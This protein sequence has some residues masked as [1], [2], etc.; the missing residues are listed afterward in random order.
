MPDTT[1]LS[2]DWRQEIEVAVRDGLACLRCGIP[3]VDDADR[4]FVRIDPEAGDHVDNVMLACPACMNSHLTHPQPFDARGLSC[5]GEQ[6]VE[7]GP[8]GPPTP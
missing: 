3:L 1:P 5:I 7:D 8:P 2:I 6:T 4:L